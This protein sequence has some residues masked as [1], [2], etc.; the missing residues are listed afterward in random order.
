M[1]RAPRLARTR[2][3]PVV[4]RHRGRAQR[5]RSRRGRSG[6]YDLPLQ[7]PADGVTPGG[8]GATPTRPTTSRVGDVDGD[9]AYEYVVKWDP[10][11]SKDVSQV[12]YTGHVYIDTY[13]LDGTLLNRI[14]LGVNIR[15]GAH[16]T[17]FL[18]Y[19]FDG[20]GR[21]RDDAEDR[22]RHE[23]DHVRRRRHRR[24]PSSYITMPEADVAAG[25]RAHRRLPAE[26]RGL[27]RAPRRD[28]PGLDASTPRSSPAT[29][30][31]RSR[32][33]L[34]I[35]RHARR[36]RCPTRTR[37]GARRLLHRRLRARAAAPATS[38]ASSRA[39]SSTAPSTSR[40]STAPP[41]RS[42]RPSTTSPAAATT[43]CCGATTRWPASSRATAST[44]SSSGVAYLD[45]KHPSAIFARGYYTRTTIA[46][47]D[48][49]GKQLKE[50]W[51]VDSG[52]VPHDQPVQR[53][54]RTAATA[55]TPST[56]RITTQGFHSLSVADVD[57]DGKQEIVYGVGDDRRRRQPAVQLVRRAAAAAAPHPGAGRAARPRRRHARH[58]HRPGPAG[59][60]DLDR[61][62]GRA[63]SRPT[64]R[65]CGTP[66]PAR[67]SSAPTP[68]GTPAAA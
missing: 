21:S 37:R 67:C 61:A 7:K 27:L 33:A 22:A 45:G 11:N 34:G 55:P 16:Y 40:C 29:G 60:G 30:R 41:A 25:V 57:G 59:P 47:Y 14:D 17:Q 18:V 32:Q 36:T 26:R 65:R 13:E 54:A 64:A 46:A 42:C 68:A 10:S 35:P 48:W 2:V 52:H 66:R 8:R 23:V 28:V 63:R 1:P 20:D 50:R 58:R 38:C 12:G 15:A 49:D 19:D 6:Y 24:E 3:A 39:S 43:A 9:G 4:Q 31:R 56:R 5:R 62:R 44:G 51:F 53:R